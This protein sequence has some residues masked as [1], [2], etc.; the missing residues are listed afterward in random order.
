MTVLPMHSWGISNT[1]G[2]VWVYHQDSADDD[3]LSSAS[4]CWSSDFQRPSRS[5]LPPACKPSGSWFQIDAECLRMSLQRVRLMQSQTRFASWARP[6]SPSASRAGWHLPNGNSSVQDVCSGMCVGHVLYL[7]CPMCVRFLI[8]C[9][10]GQW[11]LRT[12]VG[13]SCDAPPR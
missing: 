4:P 3:A 5:S 10:R 9:G 2:V 12:V 13:V 8:C 1:G 11:M 7:S 6:H